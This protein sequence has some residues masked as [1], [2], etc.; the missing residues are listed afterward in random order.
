MI[1]A[2]EDKGYK[3]PDDIE[4]IG[5]DDIDFSK[6]FYPALSTIHQDTMQIGTTAAIK[7]IQKIENK[8]PN[9]QDITFIPVKLVHRETTKK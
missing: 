7:L 1:R 5:Y 6:H 2:L 4:V 8:E 3:V 9:K